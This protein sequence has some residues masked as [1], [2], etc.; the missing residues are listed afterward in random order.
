MIV[1]A[2][3]ALLCGFLF[4]R[5][6]GSFLPEE[7]QGYALAIVQLPPGA[8]IER[9]KRVF[10]QVLDVVEKQEGYE[11]MMQVVGFS[12]V[13]RGENVGMAFIK[14]KPWDERKITA[15]QFIEN[16]NKALYGI[17]D[18]QIFVINLPT[19][20]GLGAFGGFDMYL[21][22][23]SGQGRAALGQA[24]GQL[25]GTAGKNPALTGVRPNTLADA[26]QLKL[27]VDRVQAQAMGLSVSRH[28]QRDPVDAGTRV[29]QRFRRPGPRQARDDAGRYAVPYRAR[30]VEPLLH[31][32]ADGG[33]R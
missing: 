21:Q 4:M 14:L 12:F 13:G 22:D 9:S 16:A 30:V 29:R 11:G 28:L 17:R 32:G 33:S 7:D 1:F 20:S 24:L 31:A 23:R 15:T 27:D 2:A 19:V 8:T 10:D 6:P 26:P 18:A 3:L 25:L 5:M